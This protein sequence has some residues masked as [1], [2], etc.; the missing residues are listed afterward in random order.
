MVD[1]IPITKE[2]TNAE[3]LARIVKAASKKYD[4]KMKIDFKNGKREVEFDGDEASK[5][6]IME[7]VQRIFENADENHG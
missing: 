1:K 4:C 5:A 2:D 6:F 7:D 3:V